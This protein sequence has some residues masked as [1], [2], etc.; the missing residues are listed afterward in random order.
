MS[1][2]IGQDFERQ[3]KQNVPLAGMTTLGI[4]GAARYFAVVSTAA[5]ISAGVLWARSRALPLFVLG[6]G[7]NVLVSDTG[8]NGLVLKM[9]LRGVS[10]TEDGQQVTVKAAAGEE[11]DR[12]AAELVS[13]NFAG[14]E[15]LSG[16]PGLVGATPIQNVGA[17]GQEIAETLV[18]VDAVEM[19]TGRVVSFSRIE[20]QFGYRSS[21]FKTSDLGRF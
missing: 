6:G 18:S 11:W 13:R 2:Q 19:S 12:L 17:Y 1:N 21:R 9:N 7:S 14:V 5:E 10:I 15:C 3:V 20:C 16:I 8:F 4:G